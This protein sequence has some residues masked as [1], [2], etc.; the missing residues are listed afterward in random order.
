MAKKTEPAPSTAIKGVHTTWVVRFADGT[1]VRVQAET[2][3]QA[4]ELARARVRSQ[5]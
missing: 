4:K 2:V 3:A 1:E 5:K